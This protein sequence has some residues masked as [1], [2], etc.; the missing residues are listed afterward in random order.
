M[1]TAATS[2]SAAHP[3]PI[4]EDAQNP[5][6]AVRFSGMAVHNNRI[7]FAFANS[8][9]RTIQSIEFGAAMYD[10]SEHLHR[11][12]VL[13]DVHKR[14]RAGQQATYD[15]NI[16][17]WKNSNYAAW[18]L[19]PSK[20]MFTDGTSW[21]MSPDHASCEVEQWLK[22]PSR[23]PASPLQALEQAPELGTTN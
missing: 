2:L 23:N 20:V 22:E 1:T 4:F 6:C 8:S 18:M 10:S 14:L 11:V 3:K 12:Q 9:N 5:S 16:K 19:Y 21:E 13:G 15:L 7:D 17:P